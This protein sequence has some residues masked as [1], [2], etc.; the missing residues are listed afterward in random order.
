MVS[1]LIPTLCRLDAHKRY[2]KLIAHD[3]AYGVYLVEQ[4]AT[5]RAGDSS[6]LTLCLSPVGEVVVGYQGHGLA[7]VVAKVAFLLLYIDCFL[8]FLYMILTGYQ[9]ELRT[10]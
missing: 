7:D 2:F 10:L 3:V 1:S 5:E 8:F 4:N 6:E 9:P